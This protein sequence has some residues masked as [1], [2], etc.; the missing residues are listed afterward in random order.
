MVRAD[1]EHLRGP[2]THLRR[3]DSGCRRDRSSRTLVLLLSDQ[4]WSEART[5]GREPETGYYHNAKS[6]E[7]PND[8][9][10]S[11][12]VMDK[13]EARP[14]KTSSGPATLPVSVIIAVR[15]EAKNLPRCLD[16]LCRMGEVYVVD[17]QSSDS[18]VEIARDYGA[19]VVQF[20]YHGGW[21]KKRQWAL[22]TLHLAFDWVLLLDADEALTPALAEEIGQAIRDLNRDGYYIALQMFFLGRRL[23]HCG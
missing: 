19:Q 13:P 9:V 8:I 16:T 4:E 17:S 14:A 7:I 18:T 2:Q 12:C 10:K 5:C 1:S 6:S 11:C 15:N 20:Y 22:D 23:R 21:P 3:L